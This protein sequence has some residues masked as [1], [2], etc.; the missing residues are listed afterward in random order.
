MSFIPDDKITVDTFP[1]NTLWDANRELMDSTEIVNYR[2]P[3]LYNALNTN[4]H[5]CECILPR[6]G[7]TDISM[8][9]GSYT[10]D[11]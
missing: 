8:L 7:R 1:D 5:F 6:M 9:L 3:I 2:L 11:G 4:E 10:I